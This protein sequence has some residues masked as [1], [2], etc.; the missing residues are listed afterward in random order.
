M[1]RIGGLWRGGGGSASPTRV[2]GIHQR[3]TSFGRTRIAHVEDLVALVVELVVRDE[4]AA[5]DAMCTY[6]PS[7]N[8]SWCTPRDFSPE[9]STNGDRLRLLR[10]R[11]VEQLEAGRLLPRLLALVGDRHDVADDFERVRAHVGLRQLGLHHHLRLARIGDIDRGEILRRALVREP[12][13]APPVLGD[14]DRHALAHAA[15][16]VSSCWAMQLEIPFDRVGHFA[17]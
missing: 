14:L 4:I 10:R 7:Q 17:S 8:Q 1:S 16:A 2:P 11:N 3:P 13:D 9:R 15:E 12:D 5:P 6:S